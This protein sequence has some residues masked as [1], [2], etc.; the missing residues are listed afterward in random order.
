MVMIQAPC[1]ALI[2]G[3]GIWTFFVGMAMVILCKL[4][5]K[6]PLDK[7]GQEVH[8]IAQAVRLLDGRLE[9]KGI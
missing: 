4:A 5:V 6:G 8:T 3:L 9:R 7:V 1:W 2:L